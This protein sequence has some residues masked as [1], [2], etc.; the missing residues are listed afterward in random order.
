[1]LPA[2][3]QKLKSAQRLALG[4]GA[5]LFVLK[6]W[7]WWLTNSNALLSDALESIINLVAG[8]VALYSLHLASK[9]KDLN[10]P[11]GHGKVEFI[12]AGLE[13]GL[14]L[15]AGLFIIGKGGYNFFFPQALGHLD[16][17]LAIAALSAGIHLWLGNYLLR[18]GRHHDSLTLQADG[19]HLLS[20]AYTSLALVAG[21]LFMVGFGWTWMDNLLALGVGCY[22]LFTGYRLLRTATAGIMDEA[23]HEL[24]ESLVGILERNRH[25][26]WVDVHNLRVIKYGAALHIDCHLTLP[27]YFTLHESHR[28]VKR[29]ERLL[30]THCPNPT[31]LFI[32]SDPCDPPQACTF[33]AKPDCRF[34][35]KP[36][37]R[38]ESWT[39]ENISADRPHHR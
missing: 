24:V 18:L 15:L 11:Y 37:E 39:L 30:Q 36:F 26:N 29:F 12:A 6:L 32:H 2:V 23:D 4:V 35:Q 34:R 7:A 5:G 22:I 16:L 19:K 20:D 8:S 9:P 33:C 1:M 25:P 31:E 14:I 13:G 10:H 17:G 38:K 21:F 3:S 27:Y 28:E